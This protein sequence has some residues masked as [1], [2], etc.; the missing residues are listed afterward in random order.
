MLALDGPLQFCEGPS[1]PLK[2]ISLGHDF[3]LLLMDQLQLQSIVFFEFS[4]STFKLYLQVGD[5]ALQLSDFVG[6][7]VASIFCGIFEFVKVAGEG[8][9]FFLEYSD[10][11]VFLAV[12]LFLNG[13][14]GFFLLER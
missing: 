11:V 8:S 1:L 5:L 13:E 14:L 3:Q 7:L 6:L 9:Y 2:Q 4:F 10:G 12:L